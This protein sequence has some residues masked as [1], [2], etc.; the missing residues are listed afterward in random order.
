MSWLVDSKILLRRA[1]QMV[2]MLG[3][4]LSIRKAEKVWENS[5]LTQKYLGSRIFIGK[6]K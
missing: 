1:P 6:Q 4:V 2:L 3:Y 5:E